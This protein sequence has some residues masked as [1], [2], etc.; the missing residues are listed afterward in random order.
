MPLFDRLYCLVRN[1]LCRPNWVIPNFIMGGPMVLIFIFCQAVFWSG[2]TNR[3]INVTC[4]LF[5]PFNP[6]NHARGG[7]LLYQWFFWTFNWG[8]KS[9][10]MVLGTYNSSTIFFPLFIISLSGIRKQPIL[11]GFGDYLL[12]CCLFTLPYFPLEFSRSIGGLFG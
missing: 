1:I 12:L 6:S 11:V 9:L 2:F 5:S 8:K 3:I 4:L 10:Q 7:Y